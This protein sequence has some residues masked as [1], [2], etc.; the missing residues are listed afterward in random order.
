MFVLNFID[1]K[2]LDFCFFEEFF[3]DYVVYDFWFLNNI[4]ESDLLK[5]FVCFGLLLFIRLEENVL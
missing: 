2:I 3:R 5:I 4:F 1:K